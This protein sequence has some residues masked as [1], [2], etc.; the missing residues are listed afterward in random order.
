MKALMENTKGMAI[1]KNAKI[2]AQKVRLVIDA[3]RKL[4]IEEAL[5]RLAFLNKKAAVL[6]RKVL[7]SAIANAENNQGADIEDLYIS[8]IC[9][10]DGMKLTR[11]MP[12][13]KGSGDSYVHR[14]AHIKVEVSERKKG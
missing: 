1:H 13:A 14:Y 4:S 5:N 11:M 9:V 6:V 2:S 7:L 10:D 12:R 8:K 3:V